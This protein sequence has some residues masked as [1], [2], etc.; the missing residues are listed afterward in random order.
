MESNALNTTMNVACAADKYVAPV[1]ASKYAPGGD[2][3]YSAGR[4]AG[5]KLTGQTP[6]KK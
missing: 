3:A 6:C 4:A 1:A 2:L 5:D